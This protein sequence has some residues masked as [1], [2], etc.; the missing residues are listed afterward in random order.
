MVQIV[1]DSSSDIPSYILSELGI[2]VVPAHILF[3]RKKYR[4]YYDM[5]SAQ[6]FR[7][8]DRSQPDAEYYHPERDIVAVAPDGSFAA[9]ATGRMDPVSKL[10]EVEPV[11]VH[12]NHRRKGL[13]KA[14]VLECIKQLQKHGAKAIVIL[15]AASTEGATHLYDSLGFS[16]SNVHVWVK[17]L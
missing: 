3:G 15:G 10:A 6:F 9:F 2:R 16:R 4:D 13:A 12:P 7:M 17:E 14:V 8:L 1:T 11:G 5:T